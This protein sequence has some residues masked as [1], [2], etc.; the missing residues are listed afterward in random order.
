MWKTAFTN[1]TVETQLEA[2]DKMM[3]GWCFSRYDI[4]NLK[5]WENDDA[6]MY[7]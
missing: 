2:Y 3:Y 7:E 5:E 6:L 4:I 1:Y